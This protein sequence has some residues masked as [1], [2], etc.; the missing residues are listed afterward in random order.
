MVE[1]VLRRSSLGDA[2]NVDVEMA[3]RESVVANG[4]LEEAGTL[5]PSTGRKAAELS[6]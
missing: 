3:V 4:G 1:R 6:G 2:R 5:H